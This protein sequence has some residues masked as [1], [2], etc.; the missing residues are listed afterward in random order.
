MSLTTW[1][2]VKHENCTLQVWEESRMPKMAKYRGVDLQRILG[3]H[4]NHF[5]D[6]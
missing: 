4:A 2:P 6:N 3:S 1:N 5:M